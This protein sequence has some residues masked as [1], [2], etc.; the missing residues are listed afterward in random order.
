MTAQILDGT[1][2]LKT[3]KAELTQRVAAL[4]EHGIVP[5]LGTVLVGDDPG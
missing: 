4:K 1:T 3:I 5:G 2:T